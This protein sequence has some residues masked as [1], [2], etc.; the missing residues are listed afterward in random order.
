MVNID[1]KFVVGAREVSP[2]KFADALMVAA[3][4]S[5]KKHIQE[6]LGRV[7]CPEHHEAPRVEVKGPSLDKLEFL[8]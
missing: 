7:R 3:L 6:K 4:E 5:I 2:E 1:V 8:V